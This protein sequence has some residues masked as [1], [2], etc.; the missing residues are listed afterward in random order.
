MNIINTFINYRA[1]WL[2]LALT[3]IAVFAGAL[4]IAKL[5]NPILGLDWYWYLIVWII[6]ATK[7]LITFSQRI[8]LAEN[9]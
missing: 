8:K 4:F 9:K 5:W 2:D 1:D 7:P 6:A 3:K